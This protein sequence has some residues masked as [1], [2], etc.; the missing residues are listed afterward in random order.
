MNKSTTTTKLGESRNTKIT[1]IIKYSK[2][3]NLL[4]RNSY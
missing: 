4:I 3:N 2:K 1:K